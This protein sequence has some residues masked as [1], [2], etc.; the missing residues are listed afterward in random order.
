MKTYKLK[1]QICTALQTP[2]QPDTLFGHLCWAIR[3]NDGQSALEAFLEGYAQNAPPLVLGSAFP[4]GFWPAPLLPGPSPQQEEALIDQLRSLS[5]T[6]LQ[7]LLPFCPLNENIVAERLTDFEVFDVLKWLQKLRFLPEPMLADFAANMD[8]FVILRQFLQTGCGKANL[9]CQTSVAH[10]AVNRLTGASEALYF[11]TEFTPNPTD[12]P[13]YQM[14]LM[15]DVWDACQI[16]SRFNA[17]LAGGYGKGKSRGKG[18]IRVLSIE[19]WQP[20]HA[21]NANAMLLLGSCCPSLSDPAGR[22]WQT[23]T[24]YGKLGGDWALGDNPF[25]KPVTML[26]AGSILKSGSPAAYC[27][28]LVKNLSDA[29]PKVVQ[30]ALAP[31]LAVRCEAKEAV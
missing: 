24:K 15:S 14:A 27:G 20:P 9:L 16:Q 8:S 13:I 21:P 6:R 17:A 1:L 3:Y 11:S 2:L 26:L 31:A 28:H 19:P 30:Y 12:R 29:Y 22:Y 23:A 25:K 10:N 7:E 4:E 5:R 18:H